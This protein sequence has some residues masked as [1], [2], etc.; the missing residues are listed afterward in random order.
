MVFAIIC[1]PLVALTKGGIFSFILNL[2]LTVMGWVPGIIHALLVN[3]NYNQKQ[4][5]KETKKMRKAIEK[6]NKE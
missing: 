3:S 4:Q 6:G 5:I 1:P 2:C